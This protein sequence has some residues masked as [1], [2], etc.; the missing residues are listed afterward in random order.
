MMRTDK[1]IAYVGTL[2]ELGRPYSM[3][4][5]DKEQRQ[6]Y[7]FV[8]L[9]DDSSDQFMVAG[10][11]PREVESYMN[12]HTGLINIL[13]QKPYR[14][15]VISDN[16]V[17]IGN[18]SHSNFKPTERMKKMDMFDPELCGDDVWLEVFL[19]RISS[20]QPIEIA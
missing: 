13:S 6:L 20:N 14:M 15:A 12:E 4:F 11:S 10:V 9:S 3:L 8:R 17:S 2:Q 19:N 5:V 16:K 7:I 1:N 18:E